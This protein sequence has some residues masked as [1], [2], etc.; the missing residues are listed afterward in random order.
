MNTIEVVRARAEDLQEPLR[1]L[2]KWLRDGEPVPGA[3]AEEIRHRVAA[4]DQEILTALRGDLLVGV[5]LLSF[6]PNVSLGG[7]F[8]SI[9]DLYVA[10]E[11]RRHG[12]GKTLLQAAEQR[13]RHRGV[14]YL[15]AQVEQG[16]AGRFYAANDF[17]EERGLR[18]FSRSLLLSDRK[19]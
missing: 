5:L 9:E 4:G 10:P 13:C 6:R 7:Q 3:F 8:A 19:S 18:V 2:E 14:S 17:E 12:A 11:A 1:L 15:E 16:E